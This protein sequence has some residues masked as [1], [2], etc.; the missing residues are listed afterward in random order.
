MSKIKPFINNYKW[1]ETNFQNITMIEKH[2]TKIMQQLFL[3]FRMLKKN[4]YILLKFQNVAQIVKKSYSF[5]GF[6]LK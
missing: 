3:K 4:K 5:N 6:I 2:L 1:E